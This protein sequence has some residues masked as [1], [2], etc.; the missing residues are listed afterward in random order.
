MTASSA[1]R[2]EAEVGR[3]VKRPRRAGTA[4][5]FRATVEQRLLNLES[6]LA[7]VKTRLNG[8]LLF[9][10]GT[11]MAQVILRLVA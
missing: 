1:G 4:A 3:V 10:A 6:Q 8:P 9:I 11:V 7:E 2:L 5:A